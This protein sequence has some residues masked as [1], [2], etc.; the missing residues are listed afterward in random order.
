MFLKLKLLDRLSSL[1]VGK[2]IIKQEIPALEAPVVYTV[3]RVVAVRA[4][5]TRA[6]GACMPL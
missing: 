3:A 1:E 6:K 4:P 5:V 2:H